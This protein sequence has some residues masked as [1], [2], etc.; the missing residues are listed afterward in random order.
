MNSLGEVAGLDRAGLFH[1]LRLTLAAW[2]AF[3]T[4]CLLHVENAY[5]AAMPIWVVSQSA[6]GL[7]F[8]RAV[9]RI[10][11]TLVGAAIGFAIL[12]A[13]SRVLL[14]LALLGAWVGLNAFF[15][16]MLRG[17]FG[18]GALMAGMTAAVVVLPSVLH[19][20][21]A[22]ALAL[23]R[24]EC[25]LIGVVVVTLV[26][27]YWTP[28]APRQGFYAQVRAVVHDALAYV[29]ALS[30]GGVTEQKEAEER[31]ILQRM[32]NLQ[33]NASLVT[34]GSVEGYRRLHHVDGLL[35]AALGAMVAGRA[36]AE[37]DGPGEEPG[38]LAAALD[39]LR[40]A[41]RTFEEE[42]AGADAHFFGR[43]ATYLAPQRD[44]LLA[45][46]SGLITGG[47]TFAAGSLGWLSGWPAGELAALGV[48]I[49][50]MVLRS[51]PVPRAIVPAMVRGVAAGAL[52]AALY[53]LLIQ[54]HI[55]TV[56]ELILSMAPFL[57]VGGLARASRRTVGPALDF[58][59]CFLL[60]SQAALPAVTDHLAILNGTAALLLAAG[61]VA[62]GYRV[63]P[64]RPERSAMRAAEALGA[65][66]RCMAGAGDAAEAAGHRAD[67]IRQ[68]LSLGLHQERAPALPQA[69]ASPIAALA[70]GGA[71]ARLHALHARNG[72]SPDDQR[73]TSAALER[74]G[75]LRRD[76]SGTAHGLEALAADAADRDVAA[77][78]G[79][80]ATALRA[81][82]ALLAREETA[83]VPAR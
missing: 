11:G 63:V 41:E 40:L 50:S 6:R 45:A 27:G 60:A 49:F 5:W 72:T 23:A 31:R 46:E 24:V 71:I 73:V 47:A 37:R 30:G 51:L 48:C 12:G 1:G 56:P 54:P 80:A 28:A 16:Q 78:L 77:T 33:V 35:L 42:P 44:A 32:A 21:H 22:G 29:A 64:A 58:N 14:V 83:Q 26:T 79:E 25:T 17:V 39:R 13:E 10:I 52:A 4:A 43:K 68:A 8:E 65:A 38:R 36:V 2:L 9:L 66:L 19:P 74:L 20:D 15:V 62:Q 75:G 57:L 67:A 61:V 69:G 34:A 82:R 76:P 81:S 53:R 18:Y 7:L 3:A 59:M 70:L 55:A